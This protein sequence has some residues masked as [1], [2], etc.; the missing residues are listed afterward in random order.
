MGETKSKDRN[1]VSKDSW[2]L[3]RI[4][5]TCLTCTHIPGISNVKA[6]VMSRVFEDQLEWKLNQN[7][8]TELCSL[9]IC[10]PFGLNTK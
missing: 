2:I 10:L 8:F 1:E 3:C 4:H 9:L 5:N 7:V 6:D